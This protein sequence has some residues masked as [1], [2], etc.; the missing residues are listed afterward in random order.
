MATGS[1]AFPV[2]AGFNQSGGA[3][4]YIVDSALAG[5]LQVFTP[6]SGSGGATTVG[7]FATAGATDLPGG[8]STL[9][10]SGRLV[11]DMG[12]TV[13]SAG[14]TFKKIQAV[15]PAG[16]DNNSS[17]TFGVTGPAGTATN[18]GYATFFVETGYAGA[19]AD[20]SVPGLVRML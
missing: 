11:R 12:K 2:K 13:V 16:A 10:G 7:T 17:A 9:F 8:L 3:Y 19:N 14:R 1:G 15:S 20:A 6:G 18:P 4:L 5:K